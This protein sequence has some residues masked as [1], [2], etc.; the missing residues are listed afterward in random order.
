L[1][2]VRNEQNKSILQASEPYDPAGLDIATIVQTMMFY[3]AL[4]GRGYTGLGDGQQRFVDLSGLLDLGRAVLVARL[5]PTD[6]LGG[7]WS[8][9]DED[10]P[11][12]NLRRWK[13]CR[14]VLPV[15]RP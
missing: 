4:G 14:V 2:S 9:A 10:L 13:Y 3:D 8:D 15:E 12:E 1:H 11:A 5:P 6:S 7:T